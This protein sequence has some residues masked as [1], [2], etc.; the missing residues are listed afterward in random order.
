MTVEKLGS[1]VVYDR[2]YDNVL[3]HYDVVGDKFKES[4]VLAKP[5]NQTEFS[6]LIQAQG[7]TAQLQEDGSVRFFAPKTEE[8][9]FVIASPYMFDSNHE[10]SQDVTVQLTSVKGGYRYVLTPSQTWLQA[11]ERQYPVTI[12]PTVMLSDENSTIQTTEIYSGS[13]NNNYSERNLSYVGA[14]ESNSSCFE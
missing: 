9:V 6:F 12:D 3:F 4:I 14:Y 8:P 1:S 7:L 5:T 13:P 2:V 10:H 11:E